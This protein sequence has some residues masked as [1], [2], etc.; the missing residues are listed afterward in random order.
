MAVARLAGG[1][2]KLMPR[3]YGN[4]PLSFPSMNYNQDHLNLI[5]ESMSNTVN[6]PGGTAYLS[7]IPGARA[8]WAFQRRYI[9]YF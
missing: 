4:E 8:G 9:V 7:R 1:G 3:I 5:L 2:I 6:V